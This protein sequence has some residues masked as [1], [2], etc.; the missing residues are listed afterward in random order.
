MKANIMNARC[1]AQVDISGIRIALCHGLAFGSYTR[2]QGKLLLKLSL[3]INCSAS[4]TSGFFLM[5][6]NRYLND[7]KSYKYKFT[8]TVS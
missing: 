7:C 4:F 5:V 8:L 6:N 3:K 2:K 1:F